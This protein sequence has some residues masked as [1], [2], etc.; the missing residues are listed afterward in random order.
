MNGLHRQLHVRSATSAV[1][2]AVLPRRPAARSRQ[3]R[4]QVGLRG[5]KTITLIIGL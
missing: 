4:P 2:S 5:S 1:L 3:G